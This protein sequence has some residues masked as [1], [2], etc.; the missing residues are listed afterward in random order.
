[1]SCLCCN[2]ILITLKY[3]FSLKNPL[4]EKLSLS[5]QFQLQIAFQ[6][7]GGAEGAQNYKDECNWV[8]RSS[9]CIYDCV[10]KQNPRKEKCGSETPRD[11]LRI[12]QDFIYVSVDL[13]R[14]FVTHLQ[15]PT[16]IMPQTV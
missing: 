9:F 2:S 4:E 12:Q 11:L 1:M 13:H 8:L 16:F 15:V 3:N 7:L 5:Q 10:L 14:K 6:C